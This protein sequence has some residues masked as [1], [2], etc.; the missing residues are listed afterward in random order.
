MDPHAPDPEV[1]QVVTVVDDHDVATD[2]ARIAVHGRLAAC[3][4]VDGPIESTYR[5][6]GTVQTDTE[7][8][9]VAKTVLGRSGDLVSTWSAE[10]PYD[11]PEILVVPVIGGGPGYLRW[12]A[13][14]VSGR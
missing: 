11:T 6:E 4:Q 2:L 1:V 5:W 3:V 7:W 10:H 8:R 14:A 13:D 9:V 12:V